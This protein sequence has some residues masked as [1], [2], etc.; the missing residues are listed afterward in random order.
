MIAFI[1]EH[2][3]VHGVEPIC[4]VLPIAPSTYH[5]HVAK[6]AD[7][8]KLSARAKRDLELKLEIERVFA[9]NFKVYGARK[10][11]RQILREGIVV[12]RCAIERALTKWISNAC[13][14]VL[15]LHLEDLREG[16]L[17]RKY[18]PRPVRR[19]YIP[20]SNGKLR[21]LVLLWHFRFGGCC[22]EH[23][24]VRTSHRRRSCEEVENGLHDGR[25]ARLWRRSRDSFFSPRCFDA[26]GLEKGVGDHRHQGVSMQS[27]P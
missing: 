11:W 5:D 12:A 19:I 9:E 6:R 10:V 4:K 2:R 7:P 13:R 24:T 15:Q 16:L 25:H 26:A 8:E 1:D 23:F 27:D 21:P 14:L 20:K 3:E 18:R 22:E 17:E